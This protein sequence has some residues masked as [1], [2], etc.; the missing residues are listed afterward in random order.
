M[1]KVEITPAQL[2]EDNRLCGLAVLGG[3]CKSKGEA[4]RTTLYL[5][6]Q[7]VEDV[8]ARVNAQQLEGEGLLLRAG[9]KKYCLLVLKR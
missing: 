3:L 2:E 4:R 9:K 5:G 1:P 8:D 7:K 6:D